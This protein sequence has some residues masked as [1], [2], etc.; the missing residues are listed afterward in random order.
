[1]NC[2][3]FDRRM[4]RE[5]DRRGSPAANPL[6]R[7]HAE[8]CESC[9]R[10]LDLWAEIERVLPGPSTKPDRR[11]AK[12]GDAGLPASGEDVPRSD[13][14]RR[15]AAGGWALAMAVAAVLLA[16]VWFRVETPETQLA[17][18]RPADE[19]GSERVTPGQ[20]DIGVTAGASVWAG[21]LW[22]RDLAETPWLDQTM[23][24]VRSVRDGVAPLG[25]S[26]LQV[27]SILSQ[28]GGL[29]AS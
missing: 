10:R 2:Q 16:A 1:M 26:F 11:A 27:F 14:R 29:Q 4:Q 5:L 20:P 15:E 17:G 12:V 24:A 19:T 21:E 8:T 22:V 23:P 3:Q 6:L 13:R 28:G 7:R 18:S 25:R 9:R